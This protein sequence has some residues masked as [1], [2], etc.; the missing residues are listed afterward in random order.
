MM[1]IRNPGTLWLVVGPS[2]AGK[3]SLLEGAKARLAGSDRQVFV[4][5]D[6]TRPADAGGEDHNPVSVSEFE[7]RKE[8]GA[9]CFD[10]GAHGLFYGV[11]DTMAADLDA[12]KTVI[13]NVSRAV[14]PD[15]EARYADVRVA[16]ITVPRAVLEARL[17]ARGREPE[18]EI[19]ARLA[20]AERFKLEGPAIHDFVNDRPLED[21]VEA[22]VALLT[23]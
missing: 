8:S 19:Q 3:D 13:V 22:F 16:N 11:P 21:S 2:G 4:R 9:Y 6:I 10:W 20:R 1:D 23:Q 14:I 15:A 7:R 18:E 12:G 5:R 17:R